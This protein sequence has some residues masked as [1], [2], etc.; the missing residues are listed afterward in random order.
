[1]CSLLPF[2]TVPVIQVIVVWTA[3]YS[4]IV[5]VRV[6]RQFFKMKKTIYEWLISWL[7][8]DYK[9]IRP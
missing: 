5:E 1:M 8:P 2:D 6:L 7:I 3:N 9:A 4:K